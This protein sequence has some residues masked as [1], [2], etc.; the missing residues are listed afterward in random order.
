M[1]AH[2][3][4]ESLVARGLT[5]EHDVVVLGEERQPAYDRVALS[6]AFTAGGADRL[7]LDDAAFR[8]DRAVRIA[9]GDPV[10][11]LD[12]ERRLVTT[13]SGRVVGYDVCVLATGA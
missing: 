1:V 11:A 10:V 8:D 13:R 9:L 6:T 7:R 3:L 2:R 4:L 5:E 12:T